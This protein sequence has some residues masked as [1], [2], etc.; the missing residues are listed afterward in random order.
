MDYT[1]QS[2]QLAPLTELDPRSRVWVYQSNRPFTAGELPWV[3]EQLAAFAT[4]WVSHNRQLRAAADVLHD[5]F[6]VLAVDETAAPASGCSIDSSVRFL[7]QLQGELGVDLFDR[8]NFS[9]RGG[10]GRVET[11]PRE[12]FTRRYQAGEIDGET[13][14]FDPLVKNRGELDAGFEKPLRQSWHARMV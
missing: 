7:K 3:R 9:Y 13:T 12:E 8:M 14:V 5:R 11:V 4:Q 10:E 2:R 1:S 6:V